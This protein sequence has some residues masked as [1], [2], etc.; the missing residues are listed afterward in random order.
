MTDREAWHAAV[1]GVAK[2]QIETGVRSL[3]LGRS[4]EER[5][6]YPRQYSGLENSMDSIVHGVTKSQTQLSDFHF[7]LS[8]EGK[9]LTIGP[10]GKSQGSLFKEK[11]IWGL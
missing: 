4:P 6:G 11:R 1:H 7:H 10:P 2:S 9:V 8:M 5:K 3:G